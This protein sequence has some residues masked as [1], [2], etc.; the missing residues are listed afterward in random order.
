MLNTEVMIAKKNPGADLNRY[1]LIFFQIGLIVTLGLTYIGINWTFSE[2]E[3][4]QETKVE[5]EKLLTEDIPVTEMK[6]QAVPPPPPPP[7]PEVIEVVEDDLEIEETE[8]E[9]TETS[10]DEKM[11]E[12]VQVADILDEKVEESIEE[13]PFVLVA[14]VPVYPGCENQAT[15]DARKKCMSDN[16]QQ[17]IKDE[18]NINLGA[19]LGLSGMHRIFVVFKIDHTG[20]VTDIKTRGPHEALEREAERVIKMIPQ[21][22]PGYQRNRPVGVIYNIPIT[23]EVRTNS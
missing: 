23:F 18:F 9:S 6:T 11:E 2:G 10:L 7:V 21:M 5:L 3:Y 22:T 16:I 1:K 8:I 13:V 15:N 17:L 4:T 20:K 19:E 14:R 12:V